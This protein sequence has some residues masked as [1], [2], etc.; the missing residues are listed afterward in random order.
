[1]PQIV[2][3]P[4]LDK[5]SAGHIQQVTVFPLGDTVLLGSMWARCLM[6]D[7][8]GG[9]MILE[10]CLN[11]LH[12]IVRAED[13]RC[14]WVLSGDLLE[15]LTNKGQNVGAVTEKIDPRGA[16]KIVNKDNV[17]TKVRD[18]RGTRRS[19]YIAMDKVKRMRARNWVKP[20]VSGAKVLAQLA[21]LAFKSRE[22][23]PRKG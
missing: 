10:S 14:E 3:D 11:K 2:R 8:K 12:G 19:P 15:K 7:A 18:R 1:M 20:R 6:N 13:F 23:N 5:K 16:W 22:S 9:A 21:R 17:V 4:H